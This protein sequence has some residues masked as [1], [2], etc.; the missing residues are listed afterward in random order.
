MSLFRIGWVNPRSEGDQAK[1]LHDNCAKLNLNYSNIVHVGCT[2]KGKCAT[3]GKVPSF[4]VLYDVDDGSVE[5]ACKTHKN[6]Y[7][8][9]GSRSAAACYIC[10]TRRAERDADSCKECAPKM[11]TTMTGCYSCDMLFEGGCCLKHQLQKGLMKQCPDCTVYYRKQHVCE[12]A[13][14]R[15][16]AQ[17]SK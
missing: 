5:W 13:K 16:G 7:P 4:S 8:F 1:I 15:K 17:C 3:C 9:H 10:Q 11:R 2:F 14:R 12:M 6:D